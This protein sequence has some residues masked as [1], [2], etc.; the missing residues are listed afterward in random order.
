M[1]NENL[2]PKTEMV[3]EIKNEIP[4]FEE[5][6]KDYKSDGNLNYADLSS[7]DIGTLKVYGPNPNGCSNEKGAKRNQ[8]LISTLNSKKLG[9]RKFDWWD[10]DDSVYRDGDFRAH[11]FTTSSGASLGLGGAIASGEVDYSAFRLNDGGY[12]DAKF[13]NLSAG[14]RV[15]IGA[16]GVTAK[17]ELGD[18]CSYIE[19]F[20]KEIRKEIFKI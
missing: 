12:A 17:T 18:S 4:S 9:G 13:G 7:G 11:N 8:D 1:V 20:F 6:M 3:Y 15:G 16:G 2:I 10:E 19:L 14:G 5:F